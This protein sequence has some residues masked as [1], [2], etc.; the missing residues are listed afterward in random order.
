VNHTSRKQTLHGLRRAM[1]RVLALGAVLSCF[2]AIPRAAAQTN[3]QDAPVLR[4]K[5]V[6]VVYF[7]IGKDTGDQP[8]ELQYWVERDHLDRVIDV[9]G[10][11]R[12]VRANRPIMVDSRVVKALIAGWPRFE[13]RIPSE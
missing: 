2:T 10:M 6:V 1:P 9:P 4:P 5:V 3:K 12:A 8:G 13:G 11:S 7:E